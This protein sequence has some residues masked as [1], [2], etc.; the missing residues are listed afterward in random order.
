MRHSVFIIGVPGSAKSTIW[1]LLARAC[2]HI[3]HETVFDIVDPKCVKNEELFGNMNPKTKEWK[4]GVL[5]TM[6]RDMS[7]CQGKF[8]DS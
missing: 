4:D 7:K 6:M 8:T 3:D 1:K 5:S 2:T